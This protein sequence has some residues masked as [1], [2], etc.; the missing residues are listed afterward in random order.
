VFDPIRTLAANIA[1]E[2]AYA[3]GDHRAVLF[4]SGLLLLVLVMALSGIAGSLDKHGN[5]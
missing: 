5:A 1:L 2:T 3:M 4:V